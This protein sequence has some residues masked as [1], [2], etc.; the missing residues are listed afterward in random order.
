MAGVMETK[1]KEIKIK[2]SG[3]KTKTYNID[4]NTYVKSY[5]TLPDTILDNNSLESLTRPCELIIRSHEKKFDTASEEREKFNNFVLDFYLNEKKCIAFVLFSRLGCNEGKVKPI[6]FVY[7]SKNPELNNWTL[8][9][10][11]KNINYDGKYARLVAQTAF[12]YL[13]NEY[14]EMAIKS[15]LSKEEK[16]KDPLSVSVFVANDNK[17]SLGFFAK[18][19]D[20]KIVEGKIFKGEDSSAFEKGRNRAFDVNDQ[21]EDL[22][23]LIYDDKMDVTEFLFNLNSYK[24]TI[25]KQKEIEIEQ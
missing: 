14:D 16:L 18:L 13:K 7:F 9:L 24:P 10:I 2:K 6:S 3:L 12:D 21:S 23:D 19:I 1:E 22:N 11:F 8:E 20:E 17:A 4:E 25:I 15:N 5:V